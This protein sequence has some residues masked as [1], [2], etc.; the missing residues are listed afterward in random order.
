MTPMLPSH[1]STPMVNVA[2]TILAAAVLLLL[3]G[4]V[5]IMRQH[6]YAKLYRVVPGEEHEDFGRLV[7]WIAARDGNV[8]LPVGGKIYWAETV[9]YR[10]Y[11]NETFV[12]LTCPPRFHEKRS[13]IKWVYGS[14]TPVTRGVGWAMS[15]DYGLRGP[16]TYDYPGVT[17]RPEQ[18]TQDGVFGIR[19]GDGRDRLLQLLN[20]HISDQ[21]EGNR[22]V[23]A[24][25]NKFPEV[26]RFAFGW[27]RGYPDVQTHAYL[28]R[29]R[30]VGLLY[31]RMPDSPSLAGLDFMGEDPPVLR[32]CSFIVDEELAARGRN[33]GPSL[34][35]RP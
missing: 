15:G 9:Y 17:M 5:G 16:G 13:S 31:V 29:D 8:T 32:Q 30:L 25:V 26:D 33:R 24:G 23:A 27:L 21:P 19:F 34:K 22:I 6:D 10:W 28:T 1:G 7:S 20:W 14:V 4:C 18:A 11:S 12:V 35:K 3:S 2:G